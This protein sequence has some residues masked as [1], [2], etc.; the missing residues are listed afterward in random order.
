MCGWLPVLLL[1][2]A[3]ASA[4]EPWRMASS[5]N[6]VIYAQYTPE[7]LRSYAAQ[8]ERFDKAMRVLRRLPD[9]PVG[10]ANRLTVFVVQNNETAAK[11]AGAPGGG[12][13]GF[14]QS[15][16]GTSIAVS[17]REKAE[18]WSDLTPQIVLLHEYS[19]HFMLRRFPAAYPTWFV[20][21]FAEFYSTAKFQADGGMEIGAPANH[22][23]YEIAVITNPDLPRMLADPG[24]FQGVGSMELYSFGWLLTHYLTFNEARKGQLATYLDAINRGQPA[25]EAAVK[26]FG[27]LKQLERE[28]MTYRIKPMKTV[29]MSPEELSIG[30]IDV[31]DLTPGEAAMI[32]TLIRARLATAKKP[33]RD[34]AADARRTAARWPEDV[35]VL[36]SLGEAEL[37]G[38]NLDAADA[39]ADRVLVSD[40][41]SIDALMLKA[42][43]ALRRATASTGKDDKARL[44]KEAR[45]FALSAN[46]I[47]ADHPVPLILFYR[48]FI[49]AGE[50]P[51]PNAVTG[52]TR[53]H[54]LAP[55]DA[56]LRLM[57]ATQLFDDHKPVEVRLLLT[58]IAYDP[59]GGD[60]RKEALALLAKLPAASP[61]K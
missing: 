14:Y 29:R 58:P 12:I 52:L 16:A 25:G 45:R 17:S 4:A 47:D 18:H 27:N 26:A 31:R 3:A 6:F 38:G 46:R 10:N 40:G 30:P 34:I 5:A 39:A 20:E 49:A 53:A 42:E 23:A 15:R 43:V 11:L 2:P 9:T 13:A 50:T 55:E 28:V 37:A 35:Q 56:E 51:T 44:A 33:D 22:R 32:P 8:L 1:S 41:K 57:L 61:D 21:G 59:H 19:H 36:S 54:L 48:S 60:E 7:A 24:N